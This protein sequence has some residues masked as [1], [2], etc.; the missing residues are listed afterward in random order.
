M[1]YPN[2]W[3]HESAFLSGLRPYPMRGHWLLWVMMCMNLCL[4]HYT[5]CMCRIIFIGDYIPVHLL[6]LNECLRIC[7]AFDDG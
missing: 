5:H 6:L 4:M 1:A 3:Q 2:G 7:I